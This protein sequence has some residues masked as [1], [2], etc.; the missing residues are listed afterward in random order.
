MQGRESGAT[1]ND[2]LGFTDS[3]LGLPAEH[4]KDVGSRRMSALRA[5]LNDNDEGGRGGMHQQI[6]PHSL[7]APPSLTDQDWSRT[8]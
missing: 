4:S 5:A 1:T 2:A 8:T 7:S 6:R 3:F